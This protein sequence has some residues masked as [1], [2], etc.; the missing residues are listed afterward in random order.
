M[1]D[2]VDKSL[3]IQGSGWSWL[4]YSKSTK[5]LSWMYTKDQDP[6]ETQGPQYVPIFTIDVWEHAFYP[7]YKNDKKSFFNNVWKITNWSDMEKRFENAKK[8]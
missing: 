8:L 5:Q 3:K 1:N 2:F 4:V 7:T 6:V